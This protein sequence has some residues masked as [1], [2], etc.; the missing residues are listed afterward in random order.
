MVARKRIFYLI[1]IMTAAAVI[2]GGITM[3]MLYN[4]ALEEERARL[5]VTAQSQARLLEAVARF[6]AIHSAD[7]PNGSFEATL[8]QMRDAHENYHGF[9]ETGEFTLARL[10]EN[11]IV[12]LLRHRHSDTE[13]PQPVPYD[14]ELAEPMRRAL[15]GRSGTIV[16]L[17]YRGETVMAAYE[18][19]AVLD[20]GIVAKIDM[21]EVRAPFIQAGLVAGF[22]AIMVI[23]VG[24]LLFLRVSDPMLKRMEESVE[25]YRKLFDNNLNG[26]ALHDIVTDETG[27]AIDY[28][29]LEV[30]STFEE[31]TGLIGDQIVGKPV[32]EVIP[33]IED[34]PFI[35]IYGKVALTGEPIRFEQFAEPLDKHYEIAAFSPRIGQFAAVFSDVSERVKAE[36]ALREYSE[37]LEEMVE[38]R[39]QELQ[40]A[41][42]Q[43]VRKEKLAVLGELAG[44]VGH[45]LRN[46]LGVITNAIFYLQ[47]V[48]PDAGEKVKEY[49]EIISAEALGAEKIVS[50]LLDFARVRPSDRG[51]VKVAHL[52]AETLEK[53]P[54]PETIQVTTRFAASLPDIWVDP[55]QIKQVLINLVT[56]A[57]QAMQDGGA[58]TISAKKQDG[59]VQISVIDTGHGISTEDQENLFEP[60]FTTKARGIGLGLAVSKNL[61]EANQGS[62]TYQSQEEE[63]TTF[64]IFLPIDE[65]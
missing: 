59:N 17:D 64:T 58:L 28:I 47:T 48:L 32:T 26:V 49:L 24:A 41:Q 39:T 35:E 40:S 7:Y 65:D 5:V 27:K 46:P 36:Q 13:I 57:Y 19:V 61:V 42:E 6:D 11:S 1:F 63:G 23:I 60:L 33:G 37:R 55:Q 8:S 54:P 22:A 62:I 15:Q 16:G 18:P 43:L 14:S 44:G 52:V 12:F 2:V 51:L 53:C 56:N 25:R 20:L 50:D 10:E 4:A 45:E 34:S 9:G 3:Y 38:E 31:L 30:N 29:F 21:S